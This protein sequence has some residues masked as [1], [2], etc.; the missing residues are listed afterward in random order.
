MIGLQEYHNVRTWLEQC[1]RP[2]VVT[3]RRPDGDAL[4]AVAALT[5][6]LRGWGQDPRPTLFERCPPRYAFLTNLTPWHDWDREQAK[7]T[8]ECDALVIL[9][10]C[11]LTQLEPLAAYLPQSPRTLVVDH[12][13]T[14]DAIATRPADLGLFDATAGAVSLLIAEWMKA[15]GVALTP[16]IATALL[17]GLGT[18]CG[19]FRFANTDARMLRAAAELCDAGAS[20]NTIYRAVYEQEPPAKLRLLARML[21]S[22]ELHAGGKLAVMIL[23]KADFDAVG[24]DHTLTEDLVNEPGRLAGLEATLLFTEEPDGRVH[25]NF[26]SKST[27]DVAALAARFGGGGHARAAGARPVGEWDEIVPRVIAETIAALGSL[28]A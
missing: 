7:L 12:H 6:V 8:A 19:W 27:L 16:A 9:D 5:L 3:H 23:R 25:V 24:A 21:Q 18:D 10:T 28:P 4:G 17:V 14:R 15:T 1:R 22:L 26:R 13:A 2:L 20:V 11:A